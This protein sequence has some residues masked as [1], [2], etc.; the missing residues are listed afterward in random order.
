MALFS[1][2]V[3]ILLSTLWKTTM[4]IN[5]DSQQFVAKLTSAQVELRVIL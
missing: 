5:W 4:D 3:K 1:K 2:D